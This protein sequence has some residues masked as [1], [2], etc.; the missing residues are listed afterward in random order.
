[1]EGFFFESVEAVR[2]RIIRGRQKVVQG[3]PLNLKEDNEFI[4]KEAR[5]I[6][7]EKPGP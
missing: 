2:Q 4:L 3:E 7:T 6:K 5:G 1:M